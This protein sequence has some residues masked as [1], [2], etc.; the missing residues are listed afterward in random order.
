MHAR[1]HLVRETLAPR[2][3]HAGRKPAMYPLLVLQRDAGRICCACALWKES[4]HVHGRDMG[5]LVFSTVP[6]VIESVLKMNL[7]I[8]ATRTFFSGEW[9]NARIDGMHITHKSSH[10]R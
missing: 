10:D 1:A 9:C 7:S 8:G 3:S 5:A 2:M 4:T 6:Q